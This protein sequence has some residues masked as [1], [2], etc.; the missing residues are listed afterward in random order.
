MKSGKP[1]PKTDS[2]YIGIIALMIGV[3]IISYLM[4]LQYQK[5]GRANSKAESDAEV[6]QS[7]GDFERLQTPIDRA[8][9]AK[10]I[11]ESRYRNL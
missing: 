2:G 1:N 10:N 7:L 4:V 9:D 11:I 3:A 8:Q 5:V 6:E